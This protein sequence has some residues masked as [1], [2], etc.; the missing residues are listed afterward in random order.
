[1]AGYDE[2]LKRNVKVGGGQVNRIQSKTIMLQRRMI[3]FDI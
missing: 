1:M 3:V 2:L